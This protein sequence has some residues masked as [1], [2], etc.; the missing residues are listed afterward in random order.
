MQDKVDKIDFV[1]Y[2][3]IRSG[4]IVAIPGVGRSTLYTVY[5]TLKRSFV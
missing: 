2:L 1:T 5:L 3:E 4:K